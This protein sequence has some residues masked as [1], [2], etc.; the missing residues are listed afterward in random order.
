MLQIIQGDVFELCIDIDGIDHN[1]IE[2]ITFSSKSLGLNEPLQYYDGRFTIRIEGERT[3]VFPIGFSGYDLTLT[4]L[5][6]ESL[7]IK[8][9]EK[10]EVLK[11][12]NLVQN[13]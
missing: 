5:G 1:L 2:K 6:G 10:I 13:E 3:K 7:T 12:I 8:H 11:K 4:L 9:G